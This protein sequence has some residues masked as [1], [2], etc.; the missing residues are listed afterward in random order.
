MYIGYFVV[1]QA[2]SQFL[3]NFDVLGEIVFGG[4]AHRVS[5]WALKLFTACLAGMLL[6]EFLHFT[7]RPG[8]QDAMHIL[9]LLQS[10]QQ[11]AESLPVDDP[12][13][14]AEVPAHAQEEVGPEAI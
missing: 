2:I 12:K 13:E 8:E 4:S 14:I 3:Q 5:F 6:G 10:V 11:L 1:V 7:A 9:G